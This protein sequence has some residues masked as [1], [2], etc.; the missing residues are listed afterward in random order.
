VFSESLGTLEGRGPDAKGI[1]HENNFAI[2][3]TRLKIIDLSDNA[4]QPMEVNDVIIS[5]NGEIYN[6]HSLK[7]ELQT[8]GVV[9]RT[10]SDTEVVL[11]GYVHWGIDTLLHKIDGMFAI[12]IFDK[13]MQ[14]VFF[15]RDRFGEK[16]LYYYMND[17]SFIAAS[18][19]NFIEIY[20]RKTGI[21]LQADYN[22]LAYYFCELST[23]QPY[24]IWKNILQVEPS[25]YLIYNIS[26]HAVRSNQYYSLPFQDTQL[27]SKDDI[28]SQLDYYISRSVEKRLLSDV[29]VGCLLSGGADSG[30]V[31]TYAAQLSGG[32]ISAYTVDFPFEGYSEKEKAGALTQQLKIDHIV[33][34]LVVKDFSSI[35]PEL[36]EVYGEP[37]ADSSAVATYYI[38]G[39]L[40]NETKVV[41]TGDGGDEIF[42]G[43]FNY[44]YTFQSVQFRKQF[45]NKTVNKFLRVPASKFLNRL[46][47]KYLNLGHL[48]SW[49]NESD[50]NVLIRHMGFDINRQSIFSEQVPYNKDFI[51]QYIDERLK[52]NHHSDRTHRIMRSSLFV[53]LLNDYLVKVDRSFMN[54]GIET[55]VPFLDRDL[56]EFVFS[57]DRQL[58]FENNVPKSLLKDLF[59]MKTGITLHKSKKMGFSLPVHEWIRGPLKSHILEVIDSQYVR[60]TGMFNPSFLNTIKA[61][62]YFENFANTDRIYAIYYF[63]LWNERYKVF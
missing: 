12:I 30:T 55:R 6:F 51:N 20:C 50:L 25:S 7:K 31:A 52:A 61:D 21:Q 58:L 10:E 5:F 36:I 60:G 41:L 39:T 16:P 4:N 19:V 11:N 23:P 49:A 43:Y 8:E 29:P 27:N 28:I 35:L 9:F 14:T 42:G 45:G 47:K 32:T 54:F 38:A 13:K 17:N 37:F 15:C 2:G 53:R 24:S 44:L 34:S 26:E 40:K 56:I 33:R 57:L 46:N 1:I 22:S 59:R 3:H 48:Q 62:S 63:G 18:T